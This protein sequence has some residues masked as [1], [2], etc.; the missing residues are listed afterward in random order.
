MDWKGMGEN[1][2]GSGMVQD[3]MAWDDS[4]GTDPT[5]HTRTKEQLN[6]SEEPSVTF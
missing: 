6:T 2:H 1:E 3:E 4:R 5:I